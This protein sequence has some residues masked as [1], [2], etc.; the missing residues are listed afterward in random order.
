LAL[1]DEAPAVECR[2]V[3]FEEQH[4]RTHAMMPAGSITDVKFYLIENAHLSVVKLARM[5]LQKVN[6]NK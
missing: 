6:L 2:D 4:M 5:C 3:N 1:K